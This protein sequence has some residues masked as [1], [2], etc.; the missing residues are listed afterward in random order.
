MCVAASLVVG[1]SG[2]V[3]AAASPGGPG[4]DEGGR[5]EPV[6][7]GGDE[8]ANLGYCQSDHVLTGGVA[9]PF[10]WSARTA[11]RVA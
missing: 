5:V 10:T 9:A 2:L 8:P 7:E 4:P 3:L 11:A 1:A 6:E